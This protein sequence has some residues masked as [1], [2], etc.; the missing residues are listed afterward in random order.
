LDSVKFKNCVDAH[1]PA[2]KK[3]ANVL[4]FSCKT[5]SG[6]DLC[7]NGG[8]CLVNN[9]TGLQACNCSEEWVADRIVFHQPNVSHGLGAM[10]RK[11]LMNSIFQCALPRNALF[12]FFL[13][14]LGVTIFCHLHQRYE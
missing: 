12:G 9:A 2:A 3:M 4:A 13:F 6:L 5:D 7:F 1:Q 11:Q 14:M 8:T 10:Q